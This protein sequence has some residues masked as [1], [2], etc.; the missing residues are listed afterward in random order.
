M[1]LLDILHT[2]SDGWASGGGPRVTT[3]ELVGIAVS[4]SGNVL[5][6]LSLNLQKLAH[7]KLQGSDFKGDSRRNSHGVEEEDR[8]GEEATLGGPSR[9]SEEAIIHG[10]ETDPLLPMHAVVSDR[11]PFSSV[12][13]R[14]KTGLRMSSLRLLFRS[15]SADDVQA[16]VP[17]TI[18]ITPPTPSPGTEATNGHHSNGKAES[19]NS[20]EGNYLQSKL[21][22]AL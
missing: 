16:L 18:M 4:I 7:N 19:T 12:R 2:V 17:T 6:S 8:D 22:Y 1:L 13:S 15:Q 5:I 21:W 10:D 3:R 14:P 11:N 9:S 20:A